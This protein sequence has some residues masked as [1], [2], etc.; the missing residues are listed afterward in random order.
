[1]PGASAQCDSSV[2]APLSSSSTAADNGLM[3]N[4]G[5]CIAAGSTDKS[6]LSSDSTYYGKA[7][8]AGDVSPSIDT[9]S[10]S[11]GVSLDPESTPSTFYIP[12]GEVRRLLQQ[13]GIDEDALLRALIRPASRLAR[14]Y[15]SK[16]HVG[17]AP[18]GPPSRFTGI[19]AE[20]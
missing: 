3:S 18:F 19:M 8:S 7:H 2:E 20:L 5:P 13:H 17:C 12:A 4:G 16:F 1:M 6:D 15:I 10:G 11:G 9:G 14:P